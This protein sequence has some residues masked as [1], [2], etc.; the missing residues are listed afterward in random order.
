M[1]NRTKEAFSIILLTIATNILIYVALSGD[2]CNAIL[3]LVLANIALIIRLS[4]Y[5]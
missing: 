2:K 3:G 4:M 5:E 1:K